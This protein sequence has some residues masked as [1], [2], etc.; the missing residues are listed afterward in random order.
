MRAYASDVGAGAPHK[1]RGGA[2]VVGRVGLDALVGQRLKAH[3][4]AG[5]FELCLHGRDIDLGGVAGGDGVGIVSRLDVGDVRKVEI[6]GYAVG[7][8]AV[9]LRLGS[10]RLGRRKVRRRRRALGLSG[11][12]GSCGGRGNGLLDFGR[13]CRCGCRLACRGDGEYRR[14]RVGRCG[15]CLRFRGLLGSVRADGGIELLGVGVLVI[16]ECRIFLSYM[17][18]RQGEHRVLGLHGR[19]ARRSGMSRRNCGCSRRLGH[20][21]GLVLLV[22]HRRFTFMTTSPIWTSSPSRSVAGSTS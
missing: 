3:G 6:F 2:G 8:I 18:K 15:R 4:R 13:R 16:D 1:L 19:R 11:G 20:G 12:L 10:R 22:D 7:G 14:G 21:C 17:R 9:L 5:I